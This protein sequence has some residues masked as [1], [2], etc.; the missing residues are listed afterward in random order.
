MDP[1]PLGQKAY[2]EAKAKRVAALRQTLDELYPEKVSLVL[3]LGCGHG[4][5]L[6]SYSETKPGL[7]FLGIDLISRRIQLAQTKALRRGLAHLHFLKAE[8]SELLSSLPSTIKVEEVF[9]LFPDPWPKQRHWKN[10]MIQSSLLQSLH[11]KLCPGGK[12]FFR[13]DH[14]GYFDW[15]RDKLEERRGWTFRPHCEWPHEVETIFQKIT[16]GQYH[17]LIVEAKARQ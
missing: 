15:T 5:F 10:R 1:L 7:N 9:M 13:T 12:F 11:H 6:A 17:S 4:H 2:L 16:G 3:E 14:K 8:A